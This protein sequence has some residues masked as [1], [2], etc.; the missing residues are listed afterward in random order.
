MTKSELRKIYLARQKSISSVERAARSESI[1]GTFFK[2]VDLSNTKVLH[3]FISIE[4]FNEIDTASVFRLIW[5]DFPGIQTLVPRINFKSGELESLKFTA[6]SEL[7]IN[8]WDIR[9][10]DDGEHVDAEAVDMVL[11]PG[12]CFDKQGNRVGYGKGFYDRYL[13]KCREDCVTV[14]L[15]YFEPV[16][17]ISDVHSGD[18][19]LDFC[20]TPDKIFTA[21]TP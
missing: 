21:T 15:S 13:K 10:P 3:C 2:D 1:V 5:A 6:A 19:P 14:G 18:I 16:D 7:V 4:K 17:E 11:V 8:N 12:L 20:I 9:E